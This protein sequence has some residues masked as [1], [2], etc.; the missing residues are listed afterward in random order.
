M[1]KTWLYPRTGMISG[2]GEAMANK[3]HMHVGQSGKAWFVAD[4]ENCADHIYCT[5]YADW[6]K[7]GKGFAGAHLP[8]ILVDDTQFILKGGWHTNSDAL[9]AD[10]GVD[11]FDRYLTFGAVGL[12]RLVWSP[13]NPEYDM[14]I[15]QVI[16]ADEEPKMGSFNRIKD[17]AQQLANEIERKVYYSVKS[18]G[19]GSCGPVNPE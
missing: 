18:N 16:Y 5:A 11:V 2:Q 6:D 3:Y 13:E 4:R 15:D 9:Y 19:G 12:S 8:L 14:G 1:T 10:T 7:T 17:I